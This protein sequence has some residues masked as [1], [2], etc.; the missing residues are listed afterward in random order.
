MCPPPTPV[1]AA[2]YAMHGF[3]YFSIYNEKPSDIKGNFD[4]IQ[5]VNQL[6][7]IGYPSEEKAK[8]AA[9]VTESTRNPTVLLDVD[10][11]VSFRSVDAMEKEV[12]K[13]F[14]DLSV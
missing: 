10:K 8:A 4:D 11:P 7:Q 13:H 5:S 9:E 2:A 3:P 12:R 6:D 1:T 14:A